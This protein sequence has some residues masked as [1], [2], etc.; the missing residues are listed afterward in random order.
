MTKNLI[1]YIRYLPINYWPP[2]MRCMPGA[3]VLKTRLREFISSSFVVVGRSDAVERDAKERQGPHGCGDR[4]GIHDASVLHH[5]QPFRERHLAHLDFFSFVHVLFA[6]ADAVERQE[7]VC[8]CRG[9]ARCDPDE[10]KRDDSI[11]DEARLLT[12][13]SVHHGFRGFTLSSRGACSQFIHDRIAAL[14]VLPHHQNLSFLG[15]GKYDRPVLLAEQ[16]ELFLLVGLGVYEH[17]ADE[18]LAELAREL[19]RLACLFPHFEFSHCTFP[20]VGSG[21]FFC[22]IVSD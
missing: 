13:F 21:V 19:G 14:L 12:E 10:A 7:E 6:N 20:Q 9:V 1:F 15:D 17:L 4:G 5:P 22:R 8:F 11:R 18:P 16:G 2:V 3:Y